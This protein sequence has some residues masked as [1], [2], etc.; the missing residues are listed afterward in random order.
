MSDGEHELLPIRDEDTVVARRASE[1][2]EEIRAGK[3]VTAA[4][5]DEHKAVMD[6][7]MDIIRSHGWDRKTSQALRRARTDQLVAD[8]DP[9]IAAKGIKLSQAEDGVGAGP[10]SATQVNVFND[11]PPASLAHL[12]DEKEPEDE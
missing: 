11:E 1:V 5:R 9:E 4:R 6:R 3:S 12:F 7:A 8:P 2:V 10:A